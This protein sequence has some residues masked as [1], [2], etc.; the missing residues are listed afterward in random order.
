MKLGHVQM[1]V[2][3]FTAVV[4][5]GCSQTRYVTSRGFSFQNYDYIVVNKPLTTHTT[6][7][8]YGMDLE[9]ANYLASYNFNIVGYKEYDTLSPQQ[10][11]R[12]LEMRTQVA[13]THKDSALTVSFDD[14]V[15][16]RT[17]ASFTETGAGDISKFKAREKI[18]QKVMKKM[19][20]VFVADRGLVVDDGVL[21]SP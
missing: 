2:L 12:T 20:E 6:L 14:A 13:A 16:G 4:V 10:Q 21:A 11:Q 17:M 5:C 8:L 9:F 1:A 7:S 3:T 18:V 19:T 15:T